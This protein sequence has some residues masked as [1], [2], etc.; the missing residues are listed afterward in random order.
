M[1]HLARLRQVLLLAGPERDRDSCQV[2]HLPEDA[3]PSVIRGR[4]AV[5]IDV[6][7]IVGG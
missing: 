3:T 1:R 5:N 7:L 4:H 2:S 6:V